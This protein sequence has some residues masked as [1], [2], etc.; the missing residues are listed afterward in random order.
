MSHR[1]GTHPSLEELIDHIDGDRRAGD[2]LE[3]HL[4]ACGPCRDRVEEVRQ[5]LHGLSAEPDFPDPA[6]FAEQRERIVEALPSRRVPTGG[7]RA[8][9]MTSATLAAAAVAAFLVFRAVDRAPLTDDR[10]TRSVE[11]RIDVGVVAAVEGR[12]A[13]TEAYAD[14]FSSSPP[15][16]PLGARGAT[17][18]TFPVVRESTPSARSKDDA[19]ALSSPLDASLDGTAL[20]SA[21]LVEDFA[22]LDA[23]D[24]EAVLDELEG[25]RVTL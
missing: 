2:G 11:P 15:D 17:D 12:R 5:T 25:F 7:R 23:A 16:A 10:T 8:R 19:P 1:P 9:W 14:A 20:E 18:A 21:L 6:R 22:G 4:E 24:R 13:A 3:A